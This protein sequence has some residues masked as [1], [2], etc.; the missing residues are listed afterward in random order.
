MVVL[1][2]IPAVVNLS[3]PVVNMTC[4]HVIGTWFHQVM[5]DGYRVTIMVPSKDDPYF[6]PPKD[7]P[8]VVFDGK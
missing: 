7:D 5:W 4:I 1:F 8:P 2:A 6:T 3:C